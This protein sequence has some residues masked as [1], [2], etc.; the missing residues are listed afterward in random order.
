[1]CVCVCVHICMRV[2][3]VSTC[4][5]VLYAHAYLSSVNVCVSIRVCIVRTHL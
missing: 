4:V 5:L 2:C 3:L 1:M